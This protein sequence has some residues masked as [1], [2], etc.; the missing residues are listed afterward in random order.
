[1]V[2]LS[3]SIQLP[4]PGIYLGTPPS[5]LLLQ[6]ETITYEVSYSFVTPSA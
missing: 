2:T 3:S 1:M 6:K 4:K 5:E